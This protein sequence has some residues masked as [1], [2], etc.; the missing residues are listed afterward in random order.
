MID[1]VLSRTQVGYEERLRLQQVQVEYT[2]LV[3]GGEEAAL[4]AGWTPPALETILEVISSCDSGPGRACQS[5]TFCGDN[6]PHE[7]H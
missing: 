6:H 7:L 3:Y 2:H 5:C 1:D 4:A